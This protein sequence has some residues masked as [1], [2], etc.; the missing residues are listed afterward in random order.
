MGLLF[1]MHYYQC[2]IIITRVLL[3]INIIV[4]R[5]DINVALGISRCDEPLFELLNFGLLCEYIY[6]VYFVLSS[7]NFTL[8][9]TNLNLVLV[10]NKTNFK[11]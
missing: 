4:Q 11:N 5:L 10:L 9:S 2:L 7:T 1:D 8:V 6:M 3:A